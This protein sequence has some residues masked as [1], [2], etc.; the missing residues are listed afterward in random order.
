MGKEGS[1]RD[2]G[3]P[4]GTGAAGTP[5]VRLPPSGSRPDACAIGADCGDRTRDSR[6]WGRWGICP[7]ATFPKAQTSS[8]P[9]SETGANGM[10][11]VFGMMRSCG[12]SSESYL[13]EGCA[14]PRGQLCHL[15]PLSSTAQAAQPIQMV[16]SEIAILELRQF[17][18]RPT[19]QRRQGEISRE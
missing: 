14:S 17:G 12:R 16:R 7:W 8:T 10:I 9:I 2:H 5:G 6:T 3:P 18:R 19:G 1:R 11:M 13:R 15:E 4:A